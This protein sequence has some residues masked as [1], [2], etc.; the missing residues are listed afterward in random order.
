MICEPELRKLKE[1]WNLNLSQTELE[2]IKRKL[3]MIE[4]AEV[5]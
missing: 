4:E 5:K 3:A 2:D 1:A